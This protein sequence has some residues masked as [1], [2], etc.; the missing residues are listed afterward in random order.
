MLPV[1]RVARHVCKT[2]ELAHSLCE[3][4]GV[5]FPTDDPI[6]PLVLFQEG[7]SQPVVTETAT[8]FPAHGFCDTAR[9]LAIN[10]LLESRDY[11]RVAMLAQLHHD[12][13]PPHLVSDRTGRAGTSERVE[14]PVASAGSDLDN[15]LYQSLG[16]WSAKYFYFSGHQ[17]QNFFLGLLC[18]TNVR[19]GPNCI[20]HD[21]AL[22][23][24]QK[25]LSPGDAIA[26][27]APP[28]A[29]VVAQFPE[30]RGRHCPIAALRR[31][32]YCAT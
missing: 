7:R 8:A 6:A 15:S 14:N 13:P 2:F 18:V 29:T 1:N 31:T 25:D 28:N 26:T 27:L 10:H 9:V 30:L 23:L 16:L 24:G 19:V 21:T 22:N 20:R 4:R 17:S 5:E 11:V 12:P 32:G 3:H